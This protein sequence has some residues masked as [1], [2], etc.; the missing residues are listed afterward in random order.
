LTDFIPA[1]TLSHL[2]LLG[3][4]MRCLSSSV[5]I[6]ISCNAVV[7]IAPQALSDSWYLA[8]ILAT[9]VNLVKF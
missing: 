3:S 8:S 4:I 6:P 9:L 1:P 7:A 5:N 2:R